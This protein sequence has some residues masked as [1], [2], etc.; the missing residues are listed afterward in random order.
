MTERNRNKLIGVL[1]LAM[2]EGHN[3][4]TRVDA[5][6]LADYLIEEGVVVVDS[7]E[8]DRRKS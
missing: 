5:E 4:N 7:C 1:T 2:M 3:L 8:E 6:K